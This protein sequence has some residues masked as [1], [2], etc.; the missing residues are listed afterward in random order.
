[1]N[2][3]GKFFIEESTSILQPQ[4]STLVL[5]EIYLFY[6]A[7]SF[8]NGVK[9]KR[10]GKDIIICINENKSYKKKSS[11]LRKNENKSS[12]MLL[13]RHLW[14]SRICSLLYNFNYWSDEISSVIFMFP[15]YSIERKREWEN[16]TDGITKPS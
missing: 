14:T 5:K 4:I 1:M 11:V 8:L 9:W 15:L 16:V 12:S 10:H 7:F 6:L 13:R 2:T 3:Q